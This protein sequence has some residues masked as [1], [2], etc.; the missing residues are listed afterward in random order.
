M[1]LTKEQSERYSRHIKLKEFGVEGQKKLLSSK[2]LVIG[3]GGLGSPAL[4]YLAAAGIGTIGIA[5]DD[6]VDYSNL[7]R[8]VIHYTS[9]VGIP[10]T[11]SARRKIN[12][13]NPDVKVIVHNTFITKDNIMDLIKD[14]DFI[15]YCTD[16][17]ESK[18]LI[19]DAC[20]LAKKP[21]SHGAVVRFQGQAMT[22]VP[23]KGPC[24]RCVFTK[25]PVEG[26]VKNSK[27][28]GVF[29]PLP[30]IIGNI[31]VLE[32]VKYLLGIG[33]LL[34][35]HL[36]TIEALNMEVKNMRL[37]PRN[38]DCAVCGDNPTIKDVHQSY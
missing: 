8:Q 18:F 10:K 4:M 7:Q 21:Y 1:E 14:Y 30:G 37:P 6:V 35:G 17:F 34:T 32:C 27:Q 15:L 13:L 3:T 38:C 2:V 25:P 5:D 28:I 26:A 16:N 36:L 33:K 12:E 24:Y 22:Y 23:G 19:N 31:Q 20:V 29:C 9:D 11:E